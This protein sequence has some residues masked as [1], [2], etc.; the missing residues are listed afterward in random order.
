MIKHLETKMLIEPDARPVTSQRDKGGSCPA[1]GAL[2]AHS[3]NR[4]RRR[5]DEAALEKSTSKKRKLEDR[6]RVS[7]EMLRT[8][9]ACDARDIVKYFMEE[10]SCMPD[11][12][13]VRLM[14]H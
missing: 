8:A 10:K 13:T 7:Q 2:Q 11:M 3:A 4:R 6:V 1:D 12:Q 9:V 5:Q 14:R